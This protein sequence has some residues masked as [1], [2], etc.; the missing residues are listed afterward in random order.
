MAS[1]RSLAPLPL[2]LHLVLERFERVVDDGAVARPVD[3][4]PHSADNR[5]VAA[6]HVGE[7]LTAL[8]TRVVDGTFVAAQEDAA[9]LLIAPQDETLFLPLHP[10]FRHDARRLDAQILPQARVMA[11]YVVKSE[12]EGL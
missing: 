10:V 1:R 2:E 9:G 4:L 12:E 3:Q 11:E 8:G 7:F 5:S 6:H